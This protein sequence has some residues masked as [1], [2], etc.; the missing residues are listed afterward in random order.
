MRASPGRA[1]DERALVVAANRS[2][3]MSNFRTATTPGEALAVMV[4]CFGWPILASASAMLAGF[5]GGEFSDGSLIGLMFEELVLGSVAMAVL[6]V[7][8]YDFRALY[9][10]PTW[11]GVGLALVLYVVTML[12][13]SVVTALFPAQY[14]SQPI[15]SM[16]ESATASLNVIVPMA[17][18]N[19]AYEEIFLLGFLVRGLRR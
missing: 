8:R 17:I 5:R 15:D 19:G 1:I 11:V 6:A 12:A 7:R 14:Q 16:V 2:F 18:V 13:S 4:I 9:P 10:R 3:D